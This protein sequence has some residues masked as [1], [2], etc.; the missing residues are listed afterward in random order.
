MRRHRKCRRQFLQDGRYRM[1]R[2][3]YTAGC[4]QNPSS[5]GAPVIKLKC[6][7]FL[8]TEVKKVGILGTE[9]VAYTNIGIFTLERE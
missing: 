7:P 3:R 1:R 2:A 9:V 4:V 6:T 5:I 8:S